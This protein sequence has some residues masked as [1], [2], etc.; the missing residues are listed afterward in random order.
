[1]PDGQEIR[2]PLPE[3]V[4]EVAHA[5]GVAAAR[6]VLEE[7]A[8]HCPI[9]NHVE[10]LRWNVEQTENRVRALEMSRAKLAGFLS[11]ASAVGG[12]I[13]GLVAKLF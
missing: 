13:G 7:H 9:G 11:G 4:R 2:L 10:D 8:A 5:A 3:Y 12:I 1:M 6:A